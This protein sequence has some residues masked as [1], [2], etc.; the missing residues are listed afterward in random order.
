M[1]YHAPLIEPCLIPVNRFRSTFCTI[2][3]CKL[4]RVAALALLFALFMGSVDSWTDYT[5]FDGSAGHSLSLASDLHDSSD[6]EETFLLP[7][8][9]PGRPYLLQAEAR[10]TVPVL[11]VEGVFRPDTPPPILS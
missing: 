4:F 11:A 1:V 3:G 5:G 9:R 6:S 7:E 10:R 2:L 8:K